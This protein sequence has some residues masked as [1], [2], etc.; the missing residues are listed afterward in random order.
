MMARKDNK[1]R[2]FRGERPNSHRIG[3]RIPGWIR[4]GIG[5]R[6]GL[7]RFPGLLLLL[8][9]SCSA[10]VSDPGQKATGQA[11]NTSTAASKVWPDYGRNLN[12][13]PDLSE[14]QR[15]KAYLLNSVVYMR[16]YTILRPPS[17]GGAGTILPGALPVLRD[18][19]TGRYY[20]TSHIQEDVQILVNIPPGEYELGGIQVRDTSNSG[21]LGLLFPRATRSLVYFSKGI[22][23]PT[24]KVGP[25]GMFYGGDWTALIVSKSQVSIPQPDQAAAESHR[26]MALEGLLAHFAGSRWAVLAYREKHGKRD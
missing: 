25:A 9:F 26:Q 24:I 18:T 14:S 20:Y 1:F 19:R 5:A 17:A 13:R 3:Y 7:T 2:D 12:R 4:P 6:P 11:R 16:L 10:W 8:L 22:D 21:I 23:S 15:K